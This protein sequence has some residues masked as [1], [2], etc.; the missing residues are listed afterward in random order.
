MRAAGQAEHVE[1]FVEPRFVL[2]EVGIGG[3]AQPQR[4]SRGRSRGHRVGDAAKVR[5][6]GCIGGQITQVTTDGGDL[7]GEPFLRLH[8]LEAGQQAVH[9]PG[10]D[11]RAQGESRRMLAVVLALDPGPLQ[12]RSMRQDIRRRPELLEELLGRE[13][14][15]VL[16]PLWVWNTASIAAET[17][18]SKG[19][20]KRTGLQRRGPVLDSCTANLGP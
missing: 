6:L 17:P 18:K 15:S 16:P 19:A 7:P 3:E 8:T 20:E 12:K 4:G 14:K 13:Q 1:R 5:R 2:Q 9:Q 10:H 11:V